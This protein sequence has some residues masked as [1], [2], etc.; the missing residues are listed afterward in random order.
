MQSFFVP[1]KLKITAA[2]QDWSDDLAQKLLRPWYGIVEA[3]SF[4][5]M[6]LR[7]V[8]PRLQAGLRNLEIDPSD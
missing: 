6:L 2:L 8:V 3:Q 4:D 5:N 1:V 7:S